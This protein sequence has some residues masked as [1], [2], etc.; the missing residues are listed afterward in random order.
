MLERGAFRSPPPRFRGIWTPEAESNLTGLPLS[1]ILEERMYADV[2]VIVDGTL[3]KDERFFDSVMLQS[4]INQ[5]HKDAGFDGLPTEVYIVYHDHPVQDE[6]QCHQYLTDHKPAYSW[7]IP[8]NR[9]D[10]A[11]YNPYPGDLTAEG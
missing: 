1:E 8:E 4:F 2:T 6:C 9:Q 11:D 3:D 5:V 10:A 7:N